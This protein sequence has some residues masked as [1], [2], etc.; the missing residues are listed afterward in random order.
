MLKEIFALILV[1]LFTSCGGGGK[2]TDPKTSEDGR[3]FLRNEL[4]QEVKVSYFNDNPAVGLVEVT[5]PPGKTEEISKVLLKGGSE[6]T[7]DVAV[8]YALAKIKVKID[9]NKTIRVTKAVWASGILEYEI[10]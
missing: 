2:S 9:G 3:V 6:V 1:V 5:I 4:E 8:Q 10:T 7:F